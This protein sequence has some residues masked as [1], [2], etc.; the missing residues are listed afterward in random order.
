MISR[1]FLLHVHSEL[2]SEVP[3][4]TESNTNLLR[5]TSVSPSMIN[6]SK[7][8]EGCIGSGTYETV[9]LAS[10]G[11]LISAHGCNRECMN[12]AV[13]PHDMVRCCGIG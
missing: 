8:T 13:D 5:A 1:V 10:C 3:N 12:C 11:P 6:M 9:S 4:R 2:G 7:T